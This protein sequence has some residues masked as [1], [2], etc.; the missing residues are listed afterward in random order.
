M[1]EGRALRV[2][3][4]EDETLVAAEIEE[5]LLEIGCEVVGPVATVAAIE[6]LAVSER[7]DGAVL[8]VNLRGTHVFRA[9]PLLLQ[10]GVPVILSSGYEDRSLYP[11][12][13]RELPLLVKPY[14]AEDLARAVRRAFGP[15]SPT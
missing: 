13:F 3:L 8:D 12:E 15:G 4:A 7:L 9:L 11:E 5:I 6:R 2:L 1:G 14:E 10:R